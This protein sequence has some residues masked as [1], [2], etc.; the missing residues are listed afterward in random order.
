MPGTK[1][2]PP[3]TAGTFR[4]S[5]FVEHARAQRRMTKN[6]PTCRTDSHLALAIGGVAEIT[7]SALLFDR[8]ILAVTPADGNRQLLLDGTGR[9]ASVQF[10]YSQGHKRSRME[11]LG[12]IIIAALLVL[13]WQNRCEAYIDP[14]AGGFLVQVLAPLGALAVSSLV[15]FRNKILKFFKKPQP[16]PTENGESPPSDEER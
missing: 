8:S 10:V 2:Q 4:S 11:T 1:S 13:T 14:S 16:P 5:D 15:Y 3:S 12:I 9:V 6:R 7:E